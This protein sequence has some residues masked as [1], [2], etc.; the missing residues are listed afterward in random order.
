MGLIYSVLLSWIFWKRQVLA[1]AITVS[2]S[3][4]VRRLIRGALIDLIL[5]NSGRRC[6][7]Q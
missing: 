1:T 6:G 7:V 4:G 2:V 5:F 3:R